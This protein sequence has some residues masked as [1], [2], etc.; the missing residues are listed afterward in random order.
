MPFRQWRYVGTSLDLVYGRY[1][2][3]TRSVA[4]G[5]EPR[6]HGEHAM[7][8][9]RISNSHCPDLASG[10]LILRQMP[11]RMS[12]RTTRAPVL[13][14]TNLFIELATSE[15]PPIASYMHV[16]SGSRSGCW[17]LVIVPWQ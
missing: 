14:S 6:G 13:S 4:F 5:F 10:Q 11:Q 8:F 17:A 12:P 2:I 15:Q 16:I 9:L 3:G 7:A 1:A